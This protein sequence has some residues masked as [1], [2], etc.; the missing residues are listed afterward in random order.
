MRLNQ[1]FTLIELLIVIAIIL[2]LISIALPNFL[3]AQLRAKV[4]KA[5]GEMKSLSIA[6]E[7]YASD[8]SSSNRPYLF[9]EFVQDRPM[10]RWTYGYAPDSLT[11]PV[12]YIKI[13]P[14]DPFNHGEFSIYGGQQLNY[15]AG[16]LHRHYRIAPRTPYTGFNSAWTEDSWR[17][18]LWPMM[19]KK[20]GAFQSNYILV[21]VGP[22]KVEDIIPAYH[23]LVYSPTNGTKSLGDIGI[24]SGGIGR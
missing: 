6:V 10:Y 23:P 8:R 4:T 20:W 1:G 15:P 5:M 9:G 19:T 7:A 14:E 16:H 17:T 21:S 13:H 24:H 2:I 22:D 3:E 12:A 11:T 18:Y